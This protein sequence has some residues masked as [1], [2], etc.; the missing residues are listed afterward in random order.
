MKQITGGF[1]VSC[2]FTFLLM[3]THL[4]SKVISL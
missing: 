3:W 4:Y 1:D 2:H